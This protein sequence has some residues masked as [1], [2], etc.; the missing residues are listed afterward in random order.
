MSYWLKRQR[1][2]MIKLVIFDF[3]GTIVDSKR[4]YYNSISRHL[5]PKGIKGDEINKAVAAGLNLSD[6]LRRFI[7]GFLSRWIMR[8]SIM[9]DVVG[10]VKGIKKCHDVGMIKEIHGYLKAKNGGSL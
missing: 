3:D 10:R 8:R 7:P 1:R 4:A 6:T 9:K 5:I 2:E